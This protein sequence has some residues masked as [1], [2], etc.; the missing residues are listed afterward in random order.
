MQSLIRQAA[1]TLAFLSSVLAPMPAFAD[2]TR[3]APFRAYSVADGLSQSEVYD[4]AQDRAGYLWFTTRR[5]LNRFDGR[6]FEHLTIA[7]GLMT[8]NLTAIAVAPDDSLWIGDGSGGVSVVRAGRVVRSLPPLADA[9]SLIS[10][11][12]VRDGDVLAVALDLGLVRLNYQSDDTKLLRSDGFKPRQIVSVDGDLWS[13]GSSGLHRVELDS[14]F[15][16]ALESPDIRAIY[17]A[18]ETLWVAG[19]DGRVGTWEDGEFRSVAEVSTSRPIN[20]IE[21]AQDGTIWISSS[22]ELFKIEPAADGGY[23]DSVAVR[24][25]DTFQDVVNLF[26]DREQTLW[27]SSEGGLVRAFD[28]R[29]A[30]HSLR[31]DSDPVVVWGIAE[32]RTGSFWF[33]TQ[34]ALLRESGGAL[35][36]IGP[37]NGVPYGIVRDVV[38]GAEGDI[39]AGVRGEGLY[40][41]DPNGGTGALVP[42][43]EGLEILDLVVAADGALWFGTLTAGVYRFSVSDSNLQHYASPKGAPVYALTTGEDGSVWFGADEVGLVRLEVDLAGASS[44]EVFAEDEGLEREQF[45]QIHWRAEDE[46]WVAMEEGAVYRFDRERFE[47]VAAGR[48]F[49]DQSVYLMEL[50]DDGSI[51]VGSEEGLYQFRTDDDRTVHY[52]ELTGYLGIEASVHATAFDSEGFLWLGTI[53]GVSRMDVRRPMPPSTVLTP[54][55]GRLE[56]LTDGNRVIDGAAVE[57]RQ[58]GVRVEYAAVSLTFPDNVQFSYKLAGLDTA[59]SSPTTSRTVTYSNIP[60][61]NYEF[62]VR[63]RLPGFAWHSASAPRRFTM[64]PFFWQHP[65]TIVAAAIVTLVG[66]MLLVTSRTRRER[67]INETLRSQVAKRTASIQRAKEKLQESNEKLSEEIEERRK[68]DKARVEVEARFHRAFKHAPI[69][70]GLLDREGRLFDANPALAKM[71]WPTLDEVPLA[72][73][74]DSLEGDDRGL[75]AEMFSRS[76]DPLVEHEEGKFT[77]VSSA[78]NV[79]NAQITLSTVLNDDGEYLYSIMQVLDVTESLKL[80]DKLE[81]QAMYDELTGLLNRRAFEAELTRAWEFGKEADTKSFM[82]YMDLD[83][84]KVV[85]DTSGHAAGDALLKQVSKVLL[86]SVRANDAVGRLGGDEFAIVLW[87]CPI[88]VAERIAESIR[89]GIESMRFHWDQETYRIGVSIGGVPVDSRM[90]DTGELQQLADAACYAAKEAGRNRVHIISRDQDTATLHRGQVRWVQRLRDAMDN[91]RFAI[92]GQV[93]QPVDTAIVEPERFEILLRLRD[94]KTRKL[95]PPGAFL[96]AAERY[97]L[98]LELD[99]WVVRSLFNALFVYQSF[100]AEHCCYWINLSGSSIGNERF[101]AFLKD[102]VSR[103]PLPPGTI[104]FEITERAVIRNIGEAGKLMSEL[105]EMGCKFTLDDFGSGLSSFGYLKKLPVDYLKIEGSLVRD[106]LVDDTNRIIVKSII[107]IAHTLDIQTVCEHVE[108]EEMLDTVRALGT[109]YVQGFR[110]GE[111]FVLAPSFPGTT[112]AA[113]SAS[114]SFRQQ[115]G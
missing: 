12:L 1:A 113:A 40:R 97:G 29:F 89:S 41:V 65:L 73:F 23:S 74:E 61:G 91:N 83:Q 50:L 33:A 44:Q 38:V 54:Q 36:E 110:V 103:S 86:D 6:D 71:L 79:I 14:E 62:Q 115:A 94:P 82:M 16:V 53:D 24:Q 27:L 10:D 72:K 99:E 18:G 88:D 106:I 19:E 69:G 80:T 68:S 77:F 55:V 81:Y 20:Q 76:I 5:G 70:L 51:V 47:N 87:K 52:G 7:N 28:D 34:T 46:I 108:N 42:G 107:D 39:W 92:Y 30:H 11:I 84:F 67:K 3:V 17:A 66:I 112:D 102:M 9:R 26:V 25:H 57:A 104:N 37:A 21:V 101:A 96:P 109:D 32:D 13:A 85:N 49:A 105:R 43:T 35:E 114:G 98:S 31:R 90:G 95:I 111:P 58:R 78:G 45:N 15:E 22:A 2:S 93:M 48:P 56:T 4:I 8:N 75:F 64:R 59:W 100:R 63:A 60:P